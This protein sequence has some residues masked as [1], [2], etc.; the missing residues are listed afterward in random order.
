[1]STCVRR[2]ALLMC[3][4]EL[5]NLSEGC[6]GLTFFLSVRKRLWKLF[7]M[8]SNPELI[9]MASDSM[10]NMNVEDLKHADE[11]LKYTRS[12]NDADDSKGVFGIGDYEN[13]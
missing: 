4:E 10:K 1:M 6:I 12:Y 3:I 9:K 13:D 5:G 7:Q 11:Q 2:V 8:I